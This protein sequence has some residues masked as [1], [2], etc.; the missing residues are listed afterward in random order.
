VTLL[1]IALALVGL[2]VLPGLA[3]AALSCRRHD[4]TS[5]PERFVGV[6]LAAGLST[7]LVTSE[8]LTKVGALTAGPVVLATVAIAV[9]SVVVIAGPGRPGFAILRSSAGLIALVVP[10]VVTAVAGAPLLRGVADRPQSLR[11]PTPWYYWRLVQET[12]AAHGVP[13][14]SAEWGTRVAFLDD[15]G[16]F[17]A[18]TG[19]LSVAGGS[20][21]SLVAAD[22]V[23]CLALLAAGVAVY[24]L[25][26]AWGASRPASAVA[27]GGFLALD[28]YVSKL[29]SFRPEA[30]SYALALLAAVFARWWM[31]RRRRSDLVMLGVLLFTLGQSHAIV[32]TLALAMVG[33][34]CVAGLDLGERGSRVA[35]AAR[36]VVPVVAIAL[37]MW[38]A[39][40]L[41]FGG[42]LGGAGKLGDV[43]TGAA[44][45]TW[46]FQ[47]LTTAGVLTGAP[48]A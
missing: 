31:L 24:V 10:P 36:T 34:T 47:A 40:G 26:R 43:P 27:I 42:E 45:P 12:V 3:A 29:S 22:V 48:P 15:Y 38:L 5:T 20:R 28:F 6:A 30:S 9:A 2:L 1:R 39:G 25:T 46:R 44:D 14:S 41:L 33:A 19:V 35:T 32:W 4:T 8:I 23:Q 11:Q 7:W 18:G 21:T 17:T 16:A 13:A 37:V